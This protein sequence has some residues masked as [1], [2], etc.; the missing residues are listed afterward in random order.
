MT[1]D[2]LIELEKEY[3]K[4]RWQWEELKRYGSYCPDFP[5]TF[6]DYILISRGQ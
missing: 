3:D 4:L 1:I 6:T 5:I 2:E